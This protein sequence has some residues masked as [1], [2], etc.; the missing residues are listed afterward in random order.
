[1]QNENH[2]CLR[3]GL[4]IMEL[5]FSGRVSLFQAGFLSFSKPK[6]GFERLGSGNPPASAS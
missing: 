6:S 1:M 5:F 3:A 4:L 2:K